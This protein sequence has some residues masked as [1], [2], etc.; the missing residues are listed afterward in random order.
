MVNK[1]Q[2]YLL[3]IFH[4]LISTLKMSIAD[5][6][7]RLDLTACMFSWHAYWV[8]KKNWLFIFFISHFIIIIFGDIIQCHESFCLWH[9]SLSTAVGVEFLLLILK[10]QKIFVRN[11]FLT[12]W[13]EGGFCWLILL[14]LG[15]IQE[16]ENFRLGIVQK[17]CRIEEGWEFDAG[18]QFHSN[19]HFLM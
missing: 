13:C 14:T 8:S 6:N 1:A 12:F 3:N 18:W 17:W 11:C 10:C 2:W 16:S 4:F 5:F 9:L 15:A 19:G 7:D